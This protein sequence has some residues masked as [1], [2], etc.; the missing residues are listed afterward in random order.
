MHT[1]KGCIEE[2]LLDPSRAARISC[3]PGLVPAPGQYLLAGPPGD[4]ASVIPHPLFLNAACRGGFFAA[5]PLPEGW[6]PGLELDL[7]GPLGRGFS[8][9]GA[10]RTVALADFNGAG[11]RLLALLPAALA[12]KAGV[13]LLSDHPGTGLPPELE[14]LPLA[15]LPET[16]PWADYLAVDLPRADLPELLDLLGLRPGSTRAR[17]RNMQL[18]VATPLPCGGLAECGACAV[19]LPSMRGYRLACQDGPVFDLF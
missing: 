4:P 10:A 1:A 12:Q 8:L 16:A 6:H 15:A 5:P 13:A 3:P 19:N 14:L 17:A 18:L 2:V 11:A 9:P 7:R